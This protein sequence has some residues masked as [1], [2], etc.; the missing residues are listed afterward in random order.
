MGNIGALHLARWER[1]RPAGV[2]TGGE[3]ARRRDASVPT[4]SF[5][6][7]HGSL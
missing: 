3:A 7:A 1:W 6:N 2:F 4:F 5:H